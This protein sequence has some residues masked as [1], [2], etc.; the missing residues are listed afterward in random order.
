M[1][2][3]GAHVMQLQGRVLRVNSAGLPVHTDRDLI[4]RRSS[5]LSKEPGI[6]STN[7]TACRIVE[8]TRDRS[9]PATPAATPPS[10][11]DTN[12]ILIGY[13]VRQPRKRWKTG[14]RLFLSQPSWSC[15]L[16]NL[17]ICPMSRAK[18]SLLMTLPERS[19]WCRSSIEA[20]YSAYDVERIKY[21]SKM[22]LVCTS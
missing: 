22:V 5:Q 19:E 21:P 13:R 20:I 12:N 8:L 16:A 18:E 2:A 10:F 17:P 6:L 9:M 7:A 3:K 14:L 4:G 11:E 15:E 1:L